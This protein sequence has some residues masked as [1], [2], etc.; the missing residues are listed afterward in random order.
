MT[1]TEFRT[2]V[3]DIKYGVSEGHQVTNAILLVAEILHEIE[4]SITSIYFQNRKV[5]HGDGY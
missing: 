3:S 4:I 1:D 2:K 5:D